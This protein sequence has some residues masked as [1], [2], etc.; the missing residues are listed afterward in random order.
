[1]AGRLLTLAVRSVLG[2][3]VLFCLG[4]VVFA[5]IV[6]G[7][8]DMRPERADGIVALTGGEARIDSA[9]RLLAD[10]YA[11]KLFISGV[12][13]KTSKGALRRLAPENDDLF[14]CCIEIGHEAQ[15]TTGNATET[16]EWAERA[17]FHSIIVVTSS[18]HM[19]RSL[20]ELRRAMPGIALIPHPVVTD[21]FRH[22]YWW[23]HGDAL[24]LVLSEYL[25]FIPAAARFALA[26]LLGPRAEQAIYADTGMMP[27]L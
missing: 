9:V 25:K 8:P 21:R 23:T 22:P 24:R 16:R 14:D 19:P 3:T 11:R 7:E 15:D 4:F 2:L 17:G 20:V 13:P 10:G 5:R 18:Y 12:N 26:R 6:T 1:M 27:H